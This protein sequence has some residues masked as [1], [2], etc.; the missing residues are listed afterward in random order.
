M[1]PAFV[2]AG[3][4]LIND[5]EFSF[6]DWKVPW[7]NVAKTPFGH[8]GGL[9]DNF[10]NE[11][12]MIWLLVSLIFTAFSKTKEEDEYVQKIRHDSLLWS[13][14]VNYGLLLIAILSFYEFGFF[15]VMLFNMYTPLII[16]II[17]FQYY[18]S[19]R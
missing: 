10:T 14:Y 18:Y 3:Y 11:L 19:K 5:F 9:K 15:N 17:R 12:A 16:F 7:A 6:L 1:L 2:F 8:G 4:V 13:L